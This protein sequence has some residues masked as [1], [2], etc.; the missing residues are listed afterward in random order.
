M[1]DFTL[2]NEI[3]LIIPTVHENTEHRNSYSLHSKFMFCHKTYA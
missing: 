1:N 3:H 2:V